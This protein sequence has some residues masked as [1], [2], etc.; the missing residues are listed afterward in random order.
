MDLCNVIIDYFFFLE[1][2]YKIYD[3]IMRIKA[4]PFSS[5]LLQGI[6]RIGGFHLISKLNPN[7]VHFEHRYN[8]IKN[9]LAQKTINDS[10]AIMSSPFQLNNYQSKIPFS[11][12][13]INADHL[14]SAYMRWDMH[15]Y[16]P[17]DILTKVDRATMSVSLEGREPLLDHKLIELSQQCPHALKIKNGYQKYPM[18][19]ILASYLPKELTNHPKKGFAVPLHH[20]LSNEL[21]DVVSDTLSTANFDVIE[22]FDSKQLSHLVSDFKT[23]TKSEHPLKIWYLYTF[24]SWFN[25]WGK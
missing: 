16:L 22:C 11:H 7:W 24:F 20:W 18:R 14:P 25:R 2:G 3:Q 21:Y 23:N 15:Y 8:K 17:D 12:D 4:M 5:Q 1:V 6:H 13:Y 9:I 10:M 19:K